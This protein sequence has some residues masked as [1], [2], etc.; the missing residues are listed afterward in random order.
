MGGVHTTEDGRVVGGLII[1][2][3][4]GLAQ[5]ILLSYSSANQ[6]VFSVPACFVS[7]YNLLFFFGSLKKKSAPKHKTE[8]ATSFNT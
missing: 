1:F 4:S 5:L 3:F 2:K 7:Q 8:E 6:S